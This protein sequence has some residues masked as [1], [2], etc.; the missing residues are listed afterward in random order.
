MLN[1]VRADPRLHELPIVFVSVSSTLAQLSGQWAVTKPIDRQRLTDVLG[2]AIHAPRTRVLVVAR[3]EVRPELT[4]WLDQL[5]IQ[6]RWE[7]D[8]GGAAL[9]GRQDL[10]EVALVDAGMTSA[11]AVLEHL[12]LRGRRD[13]HAVVLFA[14]G[15]HGQEPPAAV[16]VPVLPI[17]QA[18]QALRRTLDEA[19]VAGTMTRT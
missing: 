14:T 17:R 15:G 18:I 12:Q 6:Y 8:P 19:R 5:G 11:A 1:A 9:A 3:D 16:G 10:F 7:H 13:G 2:N 4:P